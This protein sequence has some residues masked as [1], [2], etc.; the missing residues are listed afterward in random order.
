[1][2]NPE[3]SDA[4]FMAKTAMSVLNWISMLYAFQCSGDAVQ[5]LH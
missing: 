3:T 1:M 4:Q 2:Y 5:R